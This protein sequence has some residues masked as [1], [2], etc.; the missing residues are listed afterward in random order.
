MNQTSDLVFVLKNVYPIAKNLVC[1]L[2]QKKIKNT[3]QEYS[4][5]IF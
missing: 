4:K 2:Y 5:K 1:I 3:T